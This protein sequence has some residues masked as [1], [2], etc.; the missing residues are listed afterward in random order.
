MEFLKNITK[1]ALKGIRLIKYKVLQPGI[2]D[3]FRVHGHYL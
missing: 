1:Y 3:R 2:I